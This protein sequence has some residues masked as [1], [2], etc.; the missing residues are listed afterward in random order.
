M[1][2]AIL[3]KRWK[4]FAAVVVAA[5]IATCAIFGELPSVLRKTR[6]VFLRPE[7]ANGIEPGTRV[8]KSGVDIGYVR[9]VHLTD[10]GDVTIEL[11]IFDG[12]GLYQSDVCVIHR[13]HRYDTATL[14]I[15]PTAGPRSS[16][17]D[18]PV[19]QCLLANG[20]WPDLRGLN[21]QS[22]N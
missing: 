13:L 19:L 15:E 7:T 10:D 4:L 20:P 9:D 3:V 2:R 6:P 14:H 22:E 5:V 21:P 17:G 12:I 18:P 1:F 16:L 11:R 8:Y